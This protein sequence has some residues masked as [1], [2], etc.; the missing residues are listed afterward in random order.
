LQKP[1]PPL[2]TPKPEQPA[3]IKIA[4]YRQAKGILALLNV[5]I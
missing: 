2:T 4:T 1:I 5:I 3:A